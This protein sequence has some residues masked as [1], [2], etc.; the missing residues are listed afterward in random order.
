MLGASEEGGCEAQRKNKHFTKILKK[1]LNV[2]LKNDF[3]QLASLL[4][5]GNDHHEAG[6][7]SAHQESESRA[8][9]SRR[10]FALRSSQQMKARKIAHKIGEQD[11]VELFGRSQ[12]SKKGRTET[13]E[14]RSFLPNEQMNASKRSH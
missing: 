1:R 3:N 14:K 7:D 6:D 12:G 9:S 13:Y 4:S 11:V 10:L 8:E 2:P 5:D